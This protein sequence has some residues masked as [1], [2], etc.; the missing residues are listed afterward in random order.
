MPYRFTV[1]CHDGDGDV[2]GVLI[3][4]MVFGENDN[5][6]EGM[7]PCILSFEQ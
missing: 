3:V 4:M 2:L 5:H 1:L 7:N 6:S